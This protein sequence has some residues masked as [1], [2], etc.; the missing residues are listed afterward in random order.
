MSNE[1]YLAIIAQGEQRRQ[2]TRMIVMLMREHDVREPT[3]INTELFRIA[4]ERV[5]IADIKKHVRRPILDV[6]AQHRLAELVLI[7][8]GIVVYKHD[9]L[10]RQVSPS[11]S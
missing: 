11:L 2:S 3:K 8:V 10:H 7:D 5:R 4:H 6:Q 1:W 9:E